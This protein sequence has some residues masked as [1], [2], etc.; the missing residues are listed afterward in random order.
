[1][2][3]EVLLDASAA[4]A[5]IYG[6]P[7]RELVRAHAGR[8]AMSAVNFAEVISKV[9]RLGVPEAQTEFLAEQLGFE[10]LDADKR[11]AAEA[12]ALHSPLHRSGVSLA[13]GF[14]L[15]LALE[16]G[17][18]VLTTDRQWASLD[19]GVEVRLIR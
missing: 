5:D 7:G 4:L 18:P 11:R 16:L 1:M 3:S 10:V 13:D 8:S 15:A 19:L 14:C 9:R 2:T 12:G 6:E 17:L